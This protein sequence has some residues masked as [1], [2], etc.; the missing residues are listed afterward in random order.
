[1]SSI[2]PSGGNAGEKKKKIPAAT[3]IETSAPQKLR[4]LPVHGGGD[5]SAEV[6]ARDSQAW[7][8]AVIDSAMDGIVV[9]DDRQRIV[10]FNPA[11]ERI[12][13]C[14]AAD[15]LGSSLDVLIPERFRKIHREAVNIFGETNLPQRE[16]GRVD[17]RALVG[18][19]ADGQEF[20]SEI[21]ISQFDDGGRKFFV[22]ILRDVSER[23]RAE[24]A[25]HESEARYRTLAEAAHDMIWIIN[26]QGVL[27]FVN[28]FGARQFGKT[29]QDLIGKPLHDLF[30]P[31]IAGRQWGNVKNVMRTGEPAYVEAVNP[32]RNRATWLG[33]SL[34]PLRDENGR[35]YAVMGVARDIT[36]RKEMEFAL[37]RHDAILEAVSFA[38]ENFLKPQG[39]QAS[40]EQV[41]G[42]LGRAAQVSRAYIYENTPD[43]EGPKLTSQRFE[44]V[45]PGVHAQIDNPA[46]QNISFQKLGLAGWMKQLSENQPMYGQIDRLP[47]GER[48]LLDAREVRSAL[49]VP[50]F[51]GPAFW[52][53]MGYDECE[54]ER[55]WSEMEI[56]ALKTAADI[57]GAAI[58]REQAEEILLASAM[59]FRSLVENSLEGIYRTSPEGKVLMANPAL[60]HMLGFDS[61]E[62]LLAQDF[63][64]DLYHR[65]ENRDLIRK[66]L[67]EADELR[68]VE[69][70]LERKDGDALI[71]LNNSRT[72]RDGGGNVLYFEGTMVDI[73]DRK[74][75]I[76][77]VNRRVNELE[78]LYESGLALSQSLDPQAIA[79]EV[80]DILGDRLHWSHASVRL[81]N[82]TSETLELL[83]FSGRHRQFPEAQ[84]RAARARAAAMKYG[85]GLAGWV[86]EHG[87]AVR[88][89]DLENEPRYLRTFAGMRSGMY[90]PMKIGDRT[91]GC[92]AVE[93]PEPQAFN[94]FDER[95]VATLGAQAAVAMENA[96]LFAQTRQR[97][98]HVSVL[99]QID[100]VITSSVDL[101]NTMDF[102]LEKLQA[103]LKVDAA[104]V[105]LLDP[106]SSTLRFFKGT[107]FRSQQLSGLSLQLG[108]NHAGR[109]ALE[110]QSI[111]I[112]DLRESPA[113]FA[114]PETLADEDFL[115]YAC[116]PLIAK[117]EVKGVLEIF[118]RAVLSWDQEWMEF[119]NV[120]AGQAAIAIDNS[121]LFDDLERSHMELSLAYDAT[122]E[123][124]SHALDLRDRETEGHTQRV[125]D[126]S[127]RLARKLGLS[128]AEIVQLRRG[129][130]LH[131]IGKMGVPDTIL[132]KPGPLTE[133]ELQIMR[134]HPQYAYEMLIPISYL[135]SA[136]NIPFAH[137]ERWDGSGYPRGLAGTDIPLTA[138][139]FAVS[140]VFDA[141]TSDRPYRKAWSQE[142]TLDY[143]RLQAGRHFDPQIVQ[144]FLSII[145]QGS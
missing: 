23:E 15:V 51:A 54:N 45:V 72:V 48:A 61:S 60:I 57:L 134:K 142:K 127:V 110:R 128:E 6:S 36:A 97:L 77:Q 119:F 66:A 121:M 131:D 28:G 111:F 67:E 52:G 7:L 116:M 42:H 25:L 108:E 49:I 29:P 63:L 47:T 74:R 11:A 24:Q 3:R 16:M 102:V 96:R 30:P 56:H 120:L 68:N 18:L 85:Q 37:Q 46:L 123:G 87:Q 99:H 83:A 39:W 101:R 50:I 34:A 4:S 38:A 33:T 22:A 86:I 98:E 125:T 143:L 93:S 9:L 138:R 135:R 109:A 144:V 14:P 132:N 88:S 107:G 71:V 12:F 40:I 64:R 141:L 27:E 17:G 133:A 75:A 79:E 117:G 2:P 73:T 80:V 114:H 43:T 95:L 139:I 92:I 1:M 65:V 137:H 8:S 78:A 103:Q 44:W 76:E 113:G 21:S 32:L 129:G 115:A 10:S 82:E 112:P 118:N 106:A 70:R 81:R 126:L 105:L 59:E 130:L 91:I 69:L 13:R 104:C 5:A 58:Q 62:E 100:L 140:D 26:P 84:F 136:L 55:E 94:E 90:I 19:R 145:E 122:I 31:E 20:P 35:I 89:A 124:W 53:M 41:L